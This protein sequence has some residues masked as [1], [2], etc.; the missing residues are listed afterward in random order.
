MSDQTGEIKRWLSFLHSYLV[1]G[2]LDG[3]CYWYVGD[4]FKLTEV[5]ELAAWYKQFMP[6]GTQL[7]WFDD[8]TIHFGKGMGWIVITNSLDTY[9][10]A[11]SQYRVKVG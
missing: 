6:V 7:Y 5:M 1:D 4:H 2:D 10:S 11:P 8:T 9:K 3:N